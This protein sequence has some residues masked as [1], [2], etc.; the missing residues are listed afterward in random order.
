MPRV[1]RF[2]LPGKKW[3]SYRAMKTARKLE[4]SVVNGFE[5]FNLFSRYGR[6]VP[7]GPDMVLLLGEATSG[8]NGL[9]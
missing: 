6:S 9:Q 5:N 7:L 1:S 8:Y 3:F 2:S 4:A